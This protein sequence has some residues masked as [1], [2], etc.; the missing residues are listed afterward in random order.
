MLQVRV[1]STLATITYIMGCG[2]SQKGEIMKS[3]QIWTNKGSTYIC[4]CSGTTPKD[5]LKRAILFWHANKQPLP[6]GFIDFVRT[7]E[8]NHKY[9][10]VETSKYRTYYYKEWIAE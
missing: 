3:Y 4:R 5:A 2:K 7:N 1:A 9:M 10:V 8:E 6:I